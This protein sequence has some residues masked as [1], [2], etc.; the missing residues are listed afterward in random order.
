MN[1]IDLKNISYTASQK[2]ILNNISLSVD[3][4]EIIA[5]LGENGAGKTTLFEVMAG[6]ICPQEGC[7][8]YFNDKKITQ[9]KK[10]IGVLWDNQLLFPSLKVK[11]II[12]YVSMM[13]GLKGKYDHSIF[14]FLELDNLKNMFMRKLSRGEKKRVEILLV[15]IHNPDILF[16]DEPTA[17]LDPIIREQIWENIFLPNNRTIIF[18]THQWEE[19]NKYATKIAFIHKGKIINTPESVETMITN[20]ELNRKIIFPKE[21]MTDFLGDY[22]IYETN[23]NKVLLLK[24]KDFQVVL[25]VVQQRTNSYSVLPVDLKDIFNYLIC[26]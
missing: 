26:K 2:K 24:E 12:N 25:P 22:F 13:Y 16:L 9:I 11:E 17:E 8:R 3:Q 10:R 21:I 14:N 23:V 20:F 19:A 15:T 4:G 1:I 18:T 6:V 7:V 5:L